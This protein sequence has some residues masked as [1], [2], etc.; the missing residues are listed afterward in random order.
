VARLHE[1]HNDAP[2][3]S[4]AIAETR[5]TPAR[6][7]DSEQELFMRG[8]IRWTAYVRERPTGTLAGFTEVMWNPAD[9]EQI[10]QGVTGVLLAYRKHGL[11]HWLKAAMLHKL[12]HEQPQPGVRVLRTGNAASNTAMLNLNH[13]LGFRTIS[14]DIWWQMSLAQVQEYLA[15]PNHVAS[16]HE[17]P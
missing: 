8:N 17:Q 11:G 10:E 1:V 14:A 9:P 5:M 2:R 7:R 12:I 15:K 4:D 16:A 6:L 13:D 3:K